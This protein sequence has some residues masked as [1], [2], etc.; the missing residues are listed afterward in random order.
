M[1]NIP[2]M[3]RFLDFFAG[4]ADLDLDERVAAD[5]RPIGLF[6]EIFFAG[7]FAGL[8]D[9]ACETCSGLSGTWVGLAAA[10]FAGLL[11]R[12]LEIGGGE[13]GEYFGLFAGFFAG[14]LRPPG[15]VGE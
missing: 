5:V 12:A 11:D 13:V 4:L 3:P 7:L 14:L 8:F 15:L 9:L 10:F 2:P 6:G 1:S